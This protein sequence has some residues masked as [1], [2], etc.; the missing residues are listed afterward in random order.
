M[1]DDKDQDTNA[2]IDPRK[3]G[4]TIKE[5][6]KDL[7]LGAIPD[8]SW[9]RMIENE[10]KAFF[11]EEIRHTVQE[12]AVPDRSR[13][14][15]GGSGFHDKKVTRLD[16]TVTPFRALVFDALQPLVRKRLADVL[17]EDKFATH[18]MRSWDTNGVQK[19]EGEV[20]KFFEDLLKEMAPDIVRLLFQGVFAHAAE[21]ARN[22]IQNAS[23]NG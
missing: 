11:H 10:I 3:L 8:E 5:K 2:L 21:S 4:E 22:A 6:V 7:F 23:M 14:Y 15:Y 17:G 1:A 13:P 12:V 16:A 18:I 20:G 9:D 19:T